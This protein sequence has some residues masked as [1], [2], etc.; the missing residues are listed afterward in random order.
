MDAHDAHAD[1]HQ[2]TSSTDAVPAWIW[3]HGVLMVIAVLV[4]MPIGIGCVLP[5]MRGRLGPAKSV[6][7]HTRVQLLAILLVLVGAA[8]GIANAESHA[9][10]PHQFLG[11]LIVATVVLFQ[12]LNAFLRP[13]KTSAHALEAALSDEAELAD[14]PKLAPAQ[15]PSEAWLSWQFYHKNAGR[16]VFL[17]ALANIVLGVL[18]AIDHV[19]E[20][21]HDH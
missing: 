14:A 18:H 15:G 2:S 11:L 5:P 20:D 21:E 3:A 16:F 13:H 8:V 17:L 19:S 9:G 6:W 1:E 7:W 4:V 12:P 10:G